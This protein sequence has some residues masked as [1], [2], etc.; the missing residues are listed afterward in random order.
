MLPTTKATVPT[1][2]YTAPTSAV[3][4]PRPPR[5]R[6]SRRNKGPIDCTCASPAR[7]RMMNRIET[8]MPGFLKN[9]T[10]TSHSVRAMAPALVSAVTSFFAVGSAQLLYRPSATMMTARMQ[11]LMVH[12]GTTPSVFSKWPASS[13]RPPVVKNLPALKKV[14]VQPAYLAWPFSSRLEMYKPSHEMSWVADEMPTSASMAMQA[15][16]Q[17][18]ACS[19]SATPPRHKPPK[20]WK[21]TTT[22]FLLLASSRKGL[23]KGLNTQAKP[24]KPVQ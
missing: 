14:P 11:K 18:G 23:H 5:L 15:A 22:S 20:I 16:N 17:N 24:I 1:V 4:S 6:A 12:A 19:A 10:I 3:V 2:P 8:Q 9:S 13:S 21:P 7:N